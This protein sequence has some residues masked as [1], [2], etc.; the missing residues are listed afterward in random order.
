MIALIKNNEKVLIESENVSIAIDWDCPD[1]D[2]GMFVSVIYSSGNT[3]R[4]GSVDRLVTLVE[5]LARLGYKHP[6]S[7]CSLLD[8]MTK[9]IESA[10][11]DGNKSDRRPKAGELLYIID[12][13]TSFTV[14]GMF[15]SESGFKSLPLRSRQ[16]P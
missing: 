9:T 3:I 13:M 5:N 15:T 4:I 11:I 7:V 6:Q 14:H 1:D 10:M 2:L 16:W 12:N 8:H